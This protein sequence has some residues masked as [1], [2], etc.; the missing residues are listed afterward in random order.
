MALPFDAA[1]V[2][3]VLSYLHPYWLDVWFTADYHGICEEK[4]GGATLHAFLSYFRYE[5]S[6]DNARI[7]NRLAPYF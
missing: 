7:F 4:R 5:S 3:G 1:V 2:F 6:T